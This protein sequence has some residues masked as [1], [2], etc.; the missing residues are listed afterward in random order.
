MTKGLY[1]RKEISRPLT[2]PALPPDGRA[3]RG[4]PS[5]PGSAIRVALC[6]LALLALTACV[7]REQEQPQELFNFEEDLQLG[8]EILAVRQVDTDSDKELEWVVFYRFDKVG[9]GGPVAALIYDV[10]RDT[11]SQLPIIYPYKLRTPDQSYLAGTEPSLSL[12]D[13]IAESTGARRSELVFSTGQ[14][15]AIFRLTRD[16][17]VFAEDNPPLYRCIGFFR[18][19]EVALDTT[20]FTV[21]VTSKAGFERSQLV[22]RTYY[23][24]ATSDQFDGYFVASTT[25]LAAPKESKVDFSDG[26]IPDGILDTPYP[27]KIVL[28]FYQTLGQ[29]SP[30]MD[31]LYYLTEQAAVEFKQGTFKFGSPFPT[32]QIQAV[33]V[34][35]LSY[36]PTQDTDKAA[37]VRARVV[38]HPKSGQPSS[39]RE[40]DWRVV[41]DKD[42]RWKIHLFVP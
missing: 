17:A 14:E 21:T 30:P 3:R 16:P 4:A 42:N 23:Q 28:A 32:D 29:T 10:V 33:I 8:K 7:R 34:K 38:F 36:Y 37:V 24:P 31:I 25:S 6:L 27:E 39:L 11:E 26:K 20:G 18:D 15:L 12:H 13:I 35:E 9:D 5:R 2:R 1:H 41:L 40:A 19:D 22:T